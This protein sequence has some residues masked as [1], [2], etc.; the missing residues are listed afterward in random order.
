MRSSIPL[1]N[2]AINLSHW[3]GDLALVVRALDEVPA[4]VRGYSYWD[5]RSFI[6]Y[7]LGDFEGAMEADRQRVGLLQPGDEWQFSITARVR[8]AQGD[9]AGARTE[10]LAQLPIAERKSAEFPELV[11][12]YLE[13]ARIHAGLGNKA[14]VLAAARKSVE[15]Q[16]PHEYRR[17]AATYFRSAPYNVLTQVLDCMGAYRSHSAHKTFGFAQRGDLR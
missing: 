10:Y 9:V 17:T 1:T 6:L 2:L 15:L 14:P 13:L 3:K 5:A 4:D 11:G 12:P 7:G 8:E 16:R